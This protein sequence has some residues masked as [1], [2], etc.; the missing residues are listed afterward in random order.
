MEEGISV[1]L[2]YAFEDTPL[3]NELEKHLALLKRQGI[4]SECIAHTVNTRNEQ[5]KGI[6]TPINA[7]IV[8]L[9]I[10]AYFVNSDYCYSV[11]MKHMMERHQ[12]GEAYVIPIILRPTDWQGAPFSNVQALP[13]N[14]RP[15]TSWGS[16]DAA[17]VNVVKGIRVVC[18][19][20]LAARAKSSSSS[21][22]RQTDS[23]SHSNI[24]QLFDV[25]KKSG[26][27]NITFVERDDFTRLKLALAQ[28]GRGVVIEGP[29][30][31]GKTTSLKKAIDS[32]TLTQSFSARDVRLSTPVTMLSARVPEHRRKLQSLLNWHNGI[33]VIDDFHRLDQSLREEVVDY[34]KYLADTETDAKKLVIVGIPHSGQMLVDLSFDVATRIEIFKWGRVQDELVLQMIEKGEEALNIGMDRKA[35][36]VIAAG[37]SLNVAQMLCSNAC[38]REKIFTTQEHFKFIQPN[39]TQAVQDTI[40][41]LS[42]K[43]KEPIR[44]F[45]VMGGHRDLTCLNILKELAQ[46]NNGV[47]SIQEFKDRRPDLAKN[48]EQFL[49]E[50]WMSKLGQEYPD[51]LNFLFFD[52]IMH[53]LAIEDPQLVFYLSKIQFDVLAREVGKS[54]APTQRD[55]SEGTSSIRDQ[56]FI[57]YSHEDKDWLEKLLIMLKPLERRGL[58][59][60][61]SDKIIEPGT[62]WREEI[63]KALASAKVAVLLV[64]PD[65]LASDFIANDELPPLLEA[66]EKEGLTILWV[67]VSYSMYKD[68]D[69]A[70]YQAV[71]NPIEPLDSLAASRVNL[72]LVLIAEK[73]KEI[74]SEI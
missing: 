48:L 38:Q 57:S 1:F 70:I 51:F 74:M 61:W 42:T 68:T 66:A 67:A 40:D 17:F 16:A 32:L 73:I 20:I 35:E 15:I 39:I 13:T 65:F 62:K 64:T 27:P 34:I 31:I 29:S 23:P 8:L 12:R 54:G 24:Y 72:E 50:N 71:N 63:N 7:D 2:S 5:A 30:G 28:P 59:K 60:T 36:I 11:E 43:F 4:V 58:I 26:V 6:N 3:E 21:I 33:V 69:I 14:G 25:F 47:L 52:P 46:S 37:G 55:V 41:E 44:R 56:I 53:T 45:V 9:L 49:Q 22:D 19:Q 10:S 18:E